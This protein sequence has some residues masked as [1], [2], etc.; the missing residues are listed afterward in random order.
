MCGRAEQTPGI[1]LTEMAS[2]WGCVVDTGIE[3]ESYCAESSVV[4]GD[5]IRYEKE[6]RAPG[7]NI[8][9]R[10]ANAKVLAG[11]LHISK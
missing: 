1:T 4:V 11:Y 9:E 10:T 8:C 3:Y 7:L 5:V 2:V 6:M